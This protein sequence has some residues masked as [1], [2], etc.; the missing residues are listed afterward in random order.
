MKWGVICNPSTKKSI[1]LAKNVYDF[2]TENGETFAEKGFAKEANLKGYT[3]KELNEKADVVATVGGDGTIL[4]TLEFVEK[5]IFAINSGGMGFLAEVESKYAISGLKQVITG[6]YNIEER[7]KL[8]IMLD[9]K[10]LP[11]AANEVTV[12]TARIAKIIYLQF[13][14]ENEL[15]E[16]LGAD[17][18]IVATP[19]GSTSYALSAGGPILDPAVN[20]MVI[21]PLAPFKLSARPWVVPLEKKIGVKLLSKTKESKIV[22]DGENAQSVN[23]ESKIIITGSEKKARF[24][25]FGESFY[26]MVRLKLVR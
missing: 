24:I 8:K 11:D 21:A 7:A 25:R 20:A 6:K 3:F 22:I 10:R 17:G 5:P 13:F 14:V 26:Q 19:T 4:K 23:M 15:V 16:T 2:L 12:Q 18:I 1:S 9:G